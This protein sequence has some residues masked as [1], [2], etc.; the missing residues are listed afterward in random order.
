MIL[1]ICAT[2]LTSIN[3]QATY[4]DPRKRHVLLRS[5]KMIRL[6]LRV[7]RCGSLIY[8]KLTRTTILCITAM[9]SGCSFAKRGVIACYLVVHAD[10]LIRTTWLAMWKA[11]PTLAF[12]CQCFGVNFL[13]HIPSRV[14]TDMHRRRRPA[15]MKWGLPKYIGLKIG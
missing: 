12:S 14:T 1:P 7:R 4:R 10:Y 3:V 13:Y 2:L 9:I 15:Y 6:A 11:T 8:L 5:G